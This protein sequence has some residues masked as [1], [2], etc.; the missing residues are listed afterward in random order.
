M[1]VLIH[2]TLSEQIIGA[3]MAALNDSKPGL[4]E[5]LHENALVEVTIRAI[6][7]IRGK[8]I[9]RNRATATT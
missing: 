8:R 1:G 7:V 3:A 6:R 5:K 4:D 2:E 9:C